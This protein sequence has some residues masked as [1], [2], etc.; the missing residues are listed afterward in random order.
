[1]SAQNQNDG[2][3]GVNDLDR[4][5]DPRK[6]PGGTV[7]HSLAEDDLSRLFNRDLDLEEMLGNSVCILFS[8]PVIIALVLLTSY[9]SY[10][11]SVRVF[12][13][14]FHGSYTELDERVQLRPRES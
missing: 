8:Q 2:N 10:L 3:E 5:I 4:Q 7:E 6:R 12:H 13:H 9:D 1:M 14:L 11:S